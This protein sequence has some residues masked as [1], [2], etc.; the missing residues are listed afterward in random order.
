MD[1]PFVGR[2]IGVKLRYPQINQYEKKVRGNITLFLA[3]IYHP[4][5][6]FENTEF[7]DMLSSIMSSVPR[8]AKLIGARCKL[9]SSND[10]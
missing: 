4:V 8:T 7:I 2:F 5:D 10:V 3:L 1:P 9:Q 6:E